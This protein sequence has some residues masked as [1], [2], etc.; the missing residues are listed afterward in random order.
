MDLAIPHFLAIAFRVAD[1][2]PLT[3]TRYGDFRENVP[4]GESVTVCALES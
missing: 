1:G 2:P 3:A 4:F